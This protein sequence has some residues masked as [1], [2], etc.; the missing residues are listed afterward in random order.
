MGKIVKFRLHRLTGFIPDDL[1]A[2][3]APPL[4]RLV[5]NPYVRML[6]SAEQAQTALIEFAKRGV[7]PPL[8]PEDKPPAT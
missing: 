3:P 6:E 8:D 5:N 7:P 2:K 1:G 4:L